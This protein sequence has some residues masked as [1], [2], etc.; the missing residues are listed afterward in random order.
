MS[1]P[2]SFIARWS[3][4][5]RELERREGPAKQEAGAQA[6]DATPQA[7]DAL[8]DDASAQPPA[9]PNVT[10]EK[11]PFDLASLPP[12]E[13]IT[14]ESDIRAFLAPGVPVELTRA[15]LRRAWAA[16][17]KIR[18]Y[19]GISENS[20][21]FNAPDSMLGFGPLEMTD[22]LR[23]EIARIVGR[24]FGMEGSDR[25]GP[26]S[27]TQQEGHAPVGTTGESGATTDATPVAQSESIDGT[28]QDQSMN[29]KNELY[30]SNADLQRSQENIAAQYP[31]EK[32]DDVQLFVKRP[33][34][35]ALPK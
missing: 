21:D 33:H 30:N 18:D 5:K 11:T 22:D 34:G 19:V 28:S 10:V 16:D 17:P 2:E 13:S 27:T 20:W 23:R 14:A 31:P 9:P 8:D 7:A 15:A 29:N 3:R 1:D 6:A 35:R 32:P 24:G 4:K 26:T 25:P 12:L